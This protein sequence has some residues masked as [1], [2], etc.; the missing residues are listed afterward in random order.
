MGVA[1]A[2]S[3]ELFAIECAE[4][5]V[6]E[7]VYVLLHRGS[8][9]L[10]VAQLAIGFAEHAELFGCLRLSFER[11]HDAVIIICRAARIGFFL[12]RFGRGRRARDR[13]RWS[14]SGTRSASLA[15]ARRCGW[16]V[17]ARR[18]AV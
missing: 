1:S 9:A 12:R 16:R 10:V 17:C 11:S 6:G 18:C 7:T 8:G 4:A 3:G 13:G 15:C 2:A 5:A 14:D